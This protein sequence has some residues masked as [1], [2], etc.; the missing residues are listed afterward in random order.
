MG[1]YASQFPH[2]FI[3]FCL[4]SECFTTTMGRMKRINFT[5]SSLRKSTTIII[6]ATMI[7]VAG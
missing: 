5:L 2:L 1:V 4:L 3:G 6:T 7:V